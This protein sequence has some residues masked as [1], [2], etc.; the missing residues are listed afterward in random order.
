MQGE[1]SR[2]AGEFRYFKITDYICALTKSL[3]PLKTVN[4]LFL[5]LLALAVVPAALRAAQAGPPDSL[6][7][8]Y[9]T[10]QALDSVYLDCSREAG[11]EKTPCLQ[12]MTD[13][14]QDRICGA[15]VH[16]ARY[17]TPQVDSLPMWKPSTE[18]DEAVMIFSSAWRWLRL[19]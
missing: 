9:C 17:G 4:R 14:L 8:S 13:R 18:G 10:R 15:F 6:Y 7:V 12:A 1:C 19:V 2:L 11:Q 3:F 16:F 5:S